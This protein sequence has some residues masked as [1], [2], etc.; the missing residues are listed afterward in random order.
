MYRKSL[1]YKTAMI[2]CVLLQIQFA[3]ADT[4][5]GRV[6]VKFD[7]GLLPISVEKDNGVIKTGISWLDSISVN[8]EMTNI[9]EMFKRPISAGLGAWF[10]L[11]FPKEHSP[12]FL[13][14]LFESEEGVIISE[15]DY[16]TVAESPNDQYFSSQWYIDSM[17]VISPQVWDDGSGTIGATDVL[18]AIIDEGWNYMHPDFDAQTNDA[19][20]IFFRNPGEEQLNYGGDFHA[21][22]QLPAIGQ[23]NGEDSDSNGFVDDRIGW[24]FVIES[25]SDTMDNNVWPDS[26]FPIEIYRNYWTSHGTVM[27]GIIAAQTNNDSGVAGIAGGWGESSGCKVLPCRTNN[28]SSVAAAINY[29]VNT[30]ADNDI[31]RLVLNL[32]IWFSDVNTMPQ[33]V[34]DAVDSAA[35]HSS[36]KCVFVASAG[37]NFEDSDSTHFP[38]DY[39]EF[40]CVA[41]VDRDYEKTVSSNW[42]PTIDIAAPG[43][44]IR[45]TTHIDSFYRTN[46]SYIGEATSAAAAMVSGVAALVWEA[47]PELSRTEVR[48]WIESAARDISATEP[49][50][51]DDLGSGVVNAADAVTGTINWFGEKAINANFVVAAERTLRIWPGTT[52]LLDSGVAVTVNGALIAEGTSGSPITFRAKDTGE[53]WS[54]LKIAGGS[55]ELDYVN[56]Q[57][58]RNYGI[59]TDAPTSVLIEHC[60]L[61]GSDL[62]SQA[63]ALLLWNA[64]SVTQTVRYTTI[65]NI[66]DGVGFYPYN[67]NVK[68]EYDTIRDC[69]NINSY[70]KKVS[71][72]IHGCVFEGRTSTYAVYF[73]SATCNPNITCC[74]FKNLA[75]SSG[76]LQTTLYSANGCSP[77]FAGDY[78]AQTLPPKSNVITD[79]SAY[80]LMFYGTG[81][82]PTIRINDWYQYSGTGKFMQ[83]Q[84]YPGTP[85]AYDVDRQYW[86]VT[87][88]TA[89]FTPSNAAY[90]DWSPYYP[91][92]W[93]LCSEDSLNGETI[94]MPDDLANQRGS[95]DDDPDEQE[96]L[97]EA[98]NLELDNEFL[99]SRDAYQRL[100]LSSSSSSVRWRA[101]LGCITTDVFCPTTASWIESYLDSLEAIE[102]SGYQ[103]HFDRTRLLYNHL[104]NQE[105]YNDAIHECSSLL[106]SGL[107]YE[108]SILIAID[109]IGIQLTAG[110]IEYGGGLDESVVSLIPRTYQVSSMTQ[111][112]LRE[113]E[114]L[115]ALNGESAKGEQNETTVPSNFSLSQNYPNPFNPTTEIEFA[116]P[117]ASNA[118]LKVYDVNGRLVTTLVNET[119]T[120]GAHRVSFDAARLPSGV[121]FY[122]LRADHHSITRKMVLLR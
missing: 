29:A 68:L 57:E 38:S 17:Y 87:P 90:W 46:Y 51:A 93:E 114:L 66:P 41:G 108:D 16:Y 83:W 36:V 18:I 103:A 76:S 74:T 110:M 61:D 6:L 49:T 26:L 73:N 81:S 55:V 12:A 65:E 100:V 50:F 24:D 47:N 84:A 13:D 22:E 11:D 78:G 85:V 116:L 72:H 97:D 52:V 62:V 75:P 106:T 107:T 121:Y 56:F 25:G 71:G 44:H 99:E 70:I 92:A 42:G 53:L 28:A 118:K 9:R 102:G 98:M 91:F 48:E 67:S 69:D 88:T 95:L 35:V 7:E 8:Y 5:D 101:M 96:Q 105:R 3:S 120:A 31:D 2:M 122:N 64:P 86:N 89:M 111:G 10:A 30:A 80:L 32:S 20:G 117:T 14:S 79:T 109:L 39:P 104:L 37:N 45:T 77:T 15:P 34:A 43:E 82:K 23:G 113:F 54:G 63:P 33:S 94:T 115:A 40:I 21:G 119:L 58:F 60:K 112:V 19:G 59:Y 27:A 4:V 1:L